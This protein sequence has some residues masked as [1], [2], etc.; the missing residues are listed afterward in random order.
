LLKLFENYKADLNK[1]KVSIYLL[2]FKE[3]DNPILQRIGVLRAETFGLVGA[4]TDKLIDI[5]ENDLLYSHI[6]IVDEVD[7]IGSY[8]VAKMTAVMKDNKLAS[9]VSN[10]YTLGDLFYEKAESMMELGRSFIQKKYWSGNYLDYLWYGIGEFVNR[11]PTID[12]LY[13]S[14]SVGNSYSLEAK[15]YIKTFVD[16]WYGEYDNLVTPIHEF[17]LSQEKYD[18]FQKELTSDEPR[19]D[20]KILK[21]KL[22][23]MGLNVPPLL[24]KYLSI[25]EEGGAKIKATAYE[26]TFKSSSFF[27]LLELNKLKELYKERYF[28]KRFYQWEILILFS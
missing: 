12:Y 4:G 19:K 24:K 28:K 1:G 9:H 11:N 18:S 6:V 26:P 8:R 2:N 27:L 23:E 25:T 22:I 5:D 20:L 13:G 10:Y 16:K 17:I 21:N 15:T 7:I 14:V 3:L